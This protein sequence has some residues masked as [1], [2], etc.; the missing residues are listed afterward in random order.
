MNVQHFSEMLNVVNEGDEDDGK[1][2]GYRILGSVNVNDHQQ[3]RDIKDGA[4]GMLL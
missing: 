2:C 3:L 1:Y 4:S